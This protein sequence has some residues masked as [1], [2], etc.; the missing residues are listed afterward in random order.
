MK[1]L[2]GLLILLGRFFLAAIFILSGIHK[3]A[4]FDA[5]VEYM[6]ATVPKMTMIPFF[7]T[8]AILIELLGGLFI[9]VGYKAR[10]GALLLFLYLI[11]VTLLF[12]NFWDAEGMAKAMQQIN[13][14]KNLAIEGGL[15]YV[16]AY[17]AGG[18]SFDARCCKVDKKS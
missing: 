9:L 12:H 5:T 18:C 11:P 13:F 17:G 16:I 6:A 14:L 10:L 2:H 7:L 1:G 8:C 3:I 15:L 4:S